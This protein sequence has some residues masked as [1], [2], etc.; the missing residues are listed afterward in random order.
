ME[1]FELIKIDMVR[2][3][4]NRFFFVTKE[5]SSETYFVYSIWLRFKTKESMWNVYPR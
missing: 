3:V 4:N 2:G 5:K 1:E